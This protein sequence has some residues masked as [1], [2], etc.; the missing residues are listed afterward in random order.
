MKMK[1][2]YIMAATVGFCCTPS[3]STAAPRP[4]IVH[5][6][7]DDLGWQDVASHKLDGKPIYETPHLDRLTRDGRRFTNAYSPAPSCA[8]SRVA[9]LRGQHPVNT[10]VYHVSGGRIPRPWHPSSPAVCPYYRYGLPVEEPMIPEALKKAGYITGHVGKWH[11]G[12]KSAGYPFPLDQGFDF[13]FTEKNGRQKY[14]NDPDLWSPEDG[15]RNQ[16]FGSWG[17]MKPDRLTEFA[18]SAPDDPYQLNEDGRPFDKPHDL[19]MGFMDKYKDRPFFLNYCPYYVHGPIQSRDRVRFEHYLKKMGHE[20]PTDAGPIYHEL[21]GQM[22]PYYASMVDTVDWMIGDVISYLEATDDPRN[23]GHKLIDNTYIIVDSDN[24]G[25]IP[26]TDNAPL[27]GGKQNTWEG[28]VRIP[29]LVRGP[30]VPA[31]SVCD[32]P[33]NLIDLFPTFMT[34]AGMEVP[35][36]IASLSRA[37]TLPAGPDS[38]TAG[39]VFRPTKDRD[40]VDLDLDGCNILPLIHGTSDKAV[41]PDGEERESIFWFFPWDAHMSAAM[42]KGE[43]KLVNHYGIPRGQNAKPVQLFRLYAQDGSTSD[44]SEA[45][46]VAEQY[47]EICNAMLAELNNFIASSGV[48][49]PHKN[50]AASSVPAEHRAASPAILERGSDKDRVWATFETGTPSAASAGSGQA[51][52]GQEGKAEI[53]EAQ[54]LYTLNPKPLDSTRGSREEWFAAPATIR[55]GRVEATM[56]PGATHAIFS[57]VDANGYL[58][59][60][61]TMPAVCDVGHQTHD[62]TILKNGYAYKPGLFALIKLGER[63]R[64]S[65]EKSGRDVSALKEALNAAKRAYETVGEGREDF[66]SYG[67][68]GG[69]VGRETFPAS[70]DIMDEMHCDAIRALRAAIRNQ[71]GATEAKHPLI[72]RFPTEPLF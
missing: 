23:P 50:L 38:P 31:G 59:H 51:G 47:P 71:K 35:N 30:R 27:R 56:P 15:N 10:G 70:V 53:V 49:V 25:V 34:M 14:Y 6:M 57:M 62:S 19:A 5:I 2:I 33:I 52:S 12:G 41:Y 45:Q 22:N 64:K 28:G 60:S 36:A 21:D 3:I 18:T 8:P 7:V 11:A 43:W 26:Y 42:R 65:A 20:F 55:E 29:F 9:F 39:K 66:P 24:G 4:N 46:N 37:G 61:E 72:N 67:D 17:R 63:A 16:F 48:P 68:G 54:L 58:L 44:L 69:Q 13:G 32:T 40:A 1:T